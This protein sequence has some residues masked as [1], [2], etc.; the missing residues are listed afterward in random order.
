MF[1]CKKNI[2]NC[3][4]KLYLHSPGFDSKGTCFPR[5]STFGLIRSVH[6]LQRSVEVVAQIRRGQEAAC[7]LEGLAQGNMH[8]GC[9]YRISFV[10]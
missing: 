4:I 3:K 6:A 1:F 8:A 5:G 10:N 9:S 2:R 7:M